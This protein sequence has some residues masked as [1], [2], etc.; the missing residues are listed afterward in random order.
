MISC[1]VETGSDEGLDFIQKGTTTEQIRYMFRVCRELKIKT[2]ADFI[3]GFPF[4]KTEADIKKN[5][6]FCFSI[7]PD[8]LIL[9]VL[10][11]YPETPIYK[12]ALEKKLI[13][14]DRWIKFCSNPTEDF[15]IDFWTEF[16]SR[17]RLIYLQQKA[18]G[19]FYL[20]L[21]YVIR[22]ILSI[23]SFEEFKL[24]VRGLYRLIINRI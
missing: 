17:E 21:S 16:F 9:S 18:L 15:Y 6:D 4:E 20:R 24:K 10:M 12:M 23:T 3:I 11:L 13:D 5:L 1:G 8:Y 7:K 2:V 19:R 22:S 14:P